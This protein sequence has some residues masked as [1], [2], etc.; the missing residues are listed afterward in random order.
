MIPYTQY[1][2]IKVDNVNN[3]VQ[4]RYDRENCLPYFNRFALSSN[5]DEEEIHQICSEG[6]EEACIF[7]HKFK[8]APEVSLVVDTGEAIVYNVDDRPDYDPNVESLVETK[9]ELDGAVNKTWQTVP[10]SNEELSANARTKRDQLL[11]ETDSYAL[12]D[13]TLSDEMREYRQSLRDVTEQSEFPTTIT[14]PQ[15]PDTE[16][17]E[18]GPTPV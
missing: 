10:F 15:P 6:S 5:F 11:Q 16:P 2:I 4:V 8:N 7:W 1:T 3:F 18:E 14:W 12:S 9:E 17:V 13:R